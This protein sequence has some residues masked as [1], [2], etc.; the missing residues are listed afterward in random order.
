MAGYY[1]EKL[2]ADR[3]RQAYGC[4]PPRIRQYLQAEIDY[5][6]GFIRPGDSVLELGC[7]YGRVL[8]ALADKTAFLTGIDTSRASLDEARC[9]VPDRVALVQTDASR[10]GLGG[11]AFDLVVCIQNGIS[12][13][14]VDPAVLFAESIRVTKKGGKVLFSSYAE[15]FWPERIVWFK[16]QAEL[17]LLGEIDPEKSTDGRIVCKDGF[18]ARTFTLTQFKQ[19]MSGFEHPF[20]LCEVDNSSVFCEI[21]VV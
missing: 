13:F 14:H 9:N 5:I 19:I 18:T 7:G 2:A 8:R 6:G 15:T 17:G 10:L 4:A 21:T 20:T 1:E 16:I 3:L 11:G 12:A